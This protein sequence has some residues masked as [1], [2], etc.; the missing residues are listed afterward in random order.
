LTVN[1]SK[2]SEVLR[3]IPEDVRFEIE[4]TKKINKTCKIIQATNYK[5]LSPFQ[6]GDVKDDKD[7]LKMDEED[8]IL[9]G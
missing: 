4:K 2:L 3:E 1:R 8:V 6:N 5:E 9:E 7:G